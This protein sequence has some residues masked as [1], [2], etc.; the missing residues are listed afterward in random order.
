MY[1]EYSNPERDYTYGIEWRF[2]NSNPQRDYND[3][4][5]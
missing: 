1:F 4:L 2:E 5:E 3:G